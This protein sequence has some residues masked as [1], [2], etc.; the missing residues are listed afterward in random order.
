MPPDPPPNRSCALGRTLLRGAAA[1][2]VLAGCLHAGYVLLGPNFHTVIP[3]AI[4]RSG[5][6]SPRELERT[7]RRF[8]IRTIIN[9]R[10]CCEPAP[11]YLQE[12][13]VTNRLNI[14]QEDLGFS[15][16]RLPSVPVLRQLV[17]V[18]DRTEYPILVH[19]HQ[20]ADRT[21]LAVAAALLLHTSTPLAEARRHLSV[22][23][24][25]LPLGR[26]T[27]MDR[28][29]DLYEEWLAG[30][31]LTHSPAT[32]RQW[33]ERD[34]CPG[35][36]RA[37]ITILSPA[38]RPMRVRRSRPTVVRVRCVNTSVKPW[39][40][41]PSSNAGIHVSYYLFDSDDEVVMSGQAGRFF[42]TVA[43]GEHIDLTLTFPPLVRKGR[44]S[45]RVD[46][47]DEQHASFLSLGCEPLFWE[48]EVL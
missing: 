8:G 18:L 9:M 21:G 5:Q 38:G 34:Y 3:G 15:A 10:G 47:V 46:L 28:F 30:H 43:P 29:F 23:T 48:V 2:L 25:H 24:G 12:C 17:E 32:F 19:C 31:R 13:A 37:V 27:N 33:V 11:W 36:G 16:G 22:R 26:T 35:E 42:A 4:Y 6:L 7:I 14:A 41:H 1:G 20:G 44:Y 40:F 39:H 45:L